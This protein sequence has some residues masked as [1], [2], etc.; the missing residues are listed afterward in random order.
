[1]IN[2]PKIVEIKD[3]IQETPT[4]KTFLFDWDEKK[5]GKPQRPLG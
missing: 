1:M 5:L 2:E 4:I 3:I